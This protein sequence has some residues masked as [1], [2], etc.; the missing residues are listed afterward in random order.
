MSDDTRNFLIAYRGREGSSPIISAIGNHPRVHVPCFEEFDHYAAGSLADPDSIIALARAALRGRPV[1]VEGRVLARARPAGKPPGPN[2]FK[3]RLWGSAGG[4]Q[5][6]LTRERV[7]LFHLFRRNLIELAASFY[8]SDVVV[9]A[10]EQAGAKFGGGGHMQFHL[11]RLPAAD[12]D[13]MRAQLAD[14]TFVI[15]QEKMRDL[16]SLILR[17]KQAQ[18]RAYLKRYAASGGQC[19]AVLYE[20]FC[21]S[22]LGFL[23]AIYRTIG[24]EPAE[25]TAV[26]AGYY[27]K[28]TSHGFLRQVENLKELQKNSE[29]RQLLKLYEH[30]IFHRHVY[31]P[32]A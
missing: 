22:R 18:Y 5:A 7:V 25:H 16:M 12:R 4:M 10:A 14:L 21:A 19:R 9:P 3:W 13:A 20:D 31:L 28:V 2:G 11:A 1:A 32:P 23:G 26:D 30:L 8:L 29:L 27:R 17:Q 15:P 6:L 24:V